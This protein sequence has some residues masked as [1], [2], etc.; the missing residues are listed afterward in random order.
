MSVVCDECSNDFAMARLNDESKTPPRLCDACFNKK[1][2]V[3]LETKSPHEIT[4]KK[5][6]G[7]DVATVLY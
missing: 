7:W 5:F 2:Q 3:L 6:K 1:I 4:F